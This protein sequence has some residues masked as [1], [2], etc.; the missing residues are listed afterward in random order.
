MEGKIIVDRLKL[1]KRFFVDE[2]AFR[3]ETSGVVM[4]KLHFSSASLELWSDE[5]TLFPGLSSSSSLSPLK[6]LS[7]FRVF[8]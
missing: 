5:Q 8:A 3:T 2:D 6:E 4:T 7:S 1:H